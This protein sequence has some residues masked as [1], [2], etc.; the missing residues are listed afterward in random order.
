MTTEE[1][2]KIFIHIMSLARRSLCNRVNPEEL[3]R[4]ED[5]INKLRAVVF[6]QENIFNLRRDA[7]MRA[8]KLWQEQTGEAL[9]WPD[10]T[11]L[12]VWLLGRIDALER[13]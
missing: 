6:E 1:A 12:C 8:I 13:N 4:V 10:H 5:G 11:D 3:D 9:I 7:D 2:E